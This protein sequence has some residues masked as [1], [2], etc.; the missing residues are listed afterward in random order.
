VAGFRV[1]TF[2]APR[3]TVGD[4]FNSLPEHGSRKMETGFRKRSC[5]NKRIS[6][7]SDS[8]QLKQTRVRRRAISVRHFSK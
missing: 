7:E 6:D 2:V 5:S 4:F 1:R 3:M 8:T